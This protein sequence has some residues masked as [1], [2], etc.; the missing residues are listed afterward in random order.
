MLKLHPIPAFNDNYIWCFYC[1]ITSQAVVVDPGCA[2]SVL[3]FMAQ[4]KLTLEAILVTHHH[5]DH[6]GGIDRLSKETGAQ[7]Y[8]F[9]Q[10]RYSGIQ[11]TYTDNEEFELL[12]SPFRVIEVPGHTLDHIAFFS[13]ANPQHTTPWLFC[14]DTLF[15]GGCGRLFE[16]SAKQMYRSLCTL[17]TLPNNTLVCCAHEYTMANLDFAMSLMPSNADLQLYKSECSYKR[18][19]GLPTLPSTLDQELKINPF[20]RESDPEILRSLDLVDSQK[21]IPPDEIW[22]HIRKAKD[23]F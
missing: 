19:Q 22:A 20:L 8:G 17:K 23:T 11:N 6:T 18:Q 13:E 9:K 3:D 10:S 12:G 16:G 5:A 14:G 1:S 15:S 2:N 21:S 7:T 4:N